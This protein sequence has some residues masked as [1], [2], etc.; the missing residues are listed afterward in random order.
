VLK[1]GGRL[2]SVAEEPPPVDP[3]HRIKVTYFIVE[4][5]R[6]QL[7]ELTAAADAGELRTEID[8]VFALEDARAAFERSLAPGK[9]GK[10]VIQ[11]APD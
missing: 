2:V 4:P 5:N 10:I 9:R 3:E 6:D 7:L 11:V 1:P 8:S